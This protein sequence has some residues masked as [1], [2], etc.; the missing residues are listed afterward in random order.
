MYS[1]CMVWYLILAHLDVSEYPMNVQ[2]SAF[3]RRGEFAVH[4]LTSSEVFHKFVLMC[5]G[6]YSTNRNFK[7]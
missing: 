4:C 3:H 5:A 7:F 2:R 1:D 6:L